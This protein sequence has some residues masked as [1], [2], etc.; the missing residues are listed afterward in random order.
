MRRSERRAEQGLTEVT[1][2]R[3]VP[4]IWAIFV[5]GNERQQIAAVQMLG[6][7]DGPSASN[8][9][10]ALAVFSPC[11]RTCAARRSRR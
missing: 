9:L 6:Q 5:R 11:G 3:A 8:G 2:P 1:D 10:A 4:M 7:I